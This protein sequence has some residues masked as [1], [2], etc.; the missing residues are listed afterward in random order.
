ML[1]VSLLKQVFE[2]LLFL[3]FSSLFFFVLFFFYELV[4]LNAQVLKLLDLSFT[5][6]FGCF[7][8]QVDHLLFF[9]L[10]LGFFSL[11]SVSLVEFSLVLG[12][13]LQF[14]PVSHFFL[15]SLL[16]FR[17]VLL[18]HDSVELLFFLLG[19]N[20]CMSFFCN[21]SL[22]LIVDKISLFLVLFTS[23]LLA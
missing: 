5:R 21:E 14:C 10:L 6:L 20:D 16:L 2:K 22:N 8:S 9:L 11:L 23:L 17:L 1:S 3:A 13:F 19:L 7:Q 12:Q 15:F 4:V 18:L